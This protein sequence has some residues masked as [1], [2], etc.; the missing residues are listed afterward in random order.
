[1]A[2]VRKLG[3][4]IGRGRAV[5]L[6]DGRR[7]VVKGDEV[8]LIQP[9]STEFVPMVLDEHVVFDNTLFIP[10]AGT[11]HR[12]IKGELGH[13]RLSMGDGYLL[14]GTPYAKSIGSSVTHGCIRMRDED[15]EWMYENVPVSTKVYIY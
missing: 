6:R 12:Q 11:K 4:D 8:G 10:P 13:Y 7:L 3:Q 2:V 14:H 5:K 15:I 9:G 1:M